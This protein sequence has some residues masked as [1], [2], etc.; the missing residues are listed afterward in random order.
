MDV[1]CTDKNKIETG[2]LHNFYIDYDETDTMDYTITAD[3]SNKE[4][5][6][7]SIWYIENTGYGGIVNYIIRFSFINKNA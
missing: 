7:R 5:Q 4:L 2:V 3:I 6:G 1:I